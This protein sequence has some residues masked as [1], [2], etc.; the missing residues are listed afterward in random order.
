RPLVDALSRDWRSAPI[1]DAERAMLAYV[2][3]L[4]LAPQRMERADVEALRAAGFDDTDILDIAQVCAY[5]NYVNRMA[6]GLGVELEPYW[7]DAS[8]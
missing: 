7:D 8:P 4:T 2:E 6:Q 3:K 5:Y 1:D